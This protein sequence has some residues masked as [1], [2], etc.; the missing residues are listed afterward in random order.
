MKILV[1]GGAGYIGSHT[2]VELL[3]A[4]HEVIIFDNFS[5]S[6]EESINRIEKITEKKVTFYKGD[7]LDE[8]ELEKVFQENSIDSVI[9]FASLKSPF[10][11]ISKP[12]SY[13]SNNIVGTLN[14]LRVM[15][16]HHCYNLVFSSS[17]T[18]YGNPK[19]VPVSEKAEKGELT[20]PYGRTKSM[21]EDI[22]SDVF[23]SNNKWNFVILRYFNPIG[24]HESGLI[25][26]DPKGIPANLFPYITQVAIGKLKEL[27][28]FGNDYNTPDGTCIR[29]YIHVVDLAKGHVFALKAFADNNQE[30][31]IYN[32]GTGKGCSVLELVKS[33]EKATGILIPYSI[34]GRRNGDVPSSYSDPTKA[35]VELSW[36]AEKNIEDMCRD[37]WNWQKKNP[38][39]YLK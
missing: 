5:N 7:C 17:A 33:F 26:E 35:N 2:S 18:V 13:Y 37:G 32:L 4:G 20:N 25:G 11:S 27:K 8:I 24:A 30:V 1:T 12:L 34:Q 36:K 19:E 15:E 10:E 9:H 31:K 39:G 3:Q 28:V 14:L 29:D 23:N 22:L 6:S 21:I 38:D 16:R